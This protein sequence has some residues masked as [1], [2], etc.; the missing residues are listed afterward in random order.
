MFVNAR[1][2]GL[3]GKQH[4][5]TNSD[6]STDF[7]HDSVVNIVCDMRPQSSIMLLV[8]NTFLID[9]LFQRVVM[10]LRKPPDYA[11]QARR[12]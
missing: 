6:C 10:E 5:N 11:L 1:Q 7:D 9:S 2:N 3:A 4:Q 8:R 12:P